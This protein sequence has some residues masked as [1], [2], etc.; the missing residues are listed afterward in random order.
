MS[1]NRRNRRAAKALAAP[2]PQPPAQP[3]P[4]PQPTIVSGPL[5][6]QNITP[7]YVDSFNISARNGMLRVAM[8][9]SGEVVNYHTVI[10]APGGAID[11][12]IDMLT[13]LK[14]GR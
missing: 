7:V 5:A 2:L 8:G 9:E 12:L 10:V 6:G 13:R 3:Q 4:Q 14:N 11:T 1:M